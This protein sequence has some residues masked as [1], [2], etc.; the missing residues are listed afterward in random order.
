MSTEPW[1]AA[2]RLDATPGLGL[3][4]CQV[5][6][7]ALGGCEEVLDAPDGLLRDV[8]GVRLWSLLRTAPPDWASRVQQVRAWL[9]AAPE[10]LRHA[11]LPWGA[12]AYP[13]ALYDLPD[14]PLLLFVA[15]AASGL[16][17]GH[18][19]KAVAVVGSRAATPQGVALAH[20]WARHMADSGWCV[21]SGLAHGIDAAA[22]RGAL[23]SEQALST[24]AVMGTGPDRVYPSAHAELKRSIARHGRC[25]TEHVPGVGARPWHFPR[26]NRL[27]AALSL[28][29]VVVEADVASGSLIS[30]QCGRTL[31]RVVMAVPGPVSSPLSRGCHALLR[32]GALLVEHPDEVIAALT[33]FP[34]SVG[35]AK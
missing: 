20:A 1:L 34:A 10:G 11:V 18:W 28:G 23:C 13:Q 9:R 24:L 5:L 30:A 26:R 2:L 29:V 32:Q 21:I 31:G 33:H 15:D 25:V 35:G 4:R 22:H 12:P 7:Q 17:H 19:P 6:T 8:L 16:D 14:P 27:L 3:R